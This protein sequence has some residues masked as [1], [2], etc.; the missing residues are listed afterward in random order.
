MAQMKRSSRARGG[1]KLALFEVIQ[2]AQAEG[3]G[4][5]SE[6][7][8][9]LVQASA[10]RE[11][12]PPPAPEPPAKTIVQ[13][14]PVTLPVERIS[15]SR[16]PRNHGRDGVGLIGFVTACAGL[17]ALGAAGFLLVQHFAKDT[18]AVV[19]GS[20]PVPDVLDVGPGAKPGS[21]DPI[22][23]NRAPAQQQTSAVP[24]AGGP[25]RVADGFRRTGGL[26][27]VIV[28]SYAASEQDLAV[29]ARDALLAAG[30]GATIERDVPGWPKRLCVV[31]TDGFE[32]I[33]TN[34]QYKA[35][36]QRLDDVSRKL[37]A[38]SRRNRKFEPQPR[39]WTH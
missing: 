13:A 4:Q 27:Y 23:A 7:V 32:H 12:S 30:I 5:L 10:T 36:R 29:A 34:A 24:G 11:P 28:Q 22:M 38:Q 1:G 9:P 17:I 16:A 33:T 37:T 26:N 31:G 19:S 6:A 15:T 25:V 14:R 35:Y 8:A 21:R 39:Q 18:P 2:A 20:Q 3:P